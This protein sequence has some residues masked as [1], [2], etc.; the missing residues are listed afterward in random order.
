MARLKEK[1][2]KGR[3]VSDIWGRFAL[4]GSQIAILVSA[5]TMLMVTVNAYVPIS[6]WLTG[7]GISVQ[8]WVFIVIILVPII[9]AYILAWKY[10]VKPFYRSSVEQFW[11][12]D[13]PLAKEIAEIKEILGNEL[14]EIRRRLEDLEKK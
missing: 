3:R 9:I 4:A 12:Q 11:L 14:P 2:L 5:Y 10:L 13:N 8:F 7:Y 1:I 6:S